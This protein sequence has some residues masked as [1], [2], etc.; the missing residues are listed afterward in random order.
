MSHNGNS[1]VFF[2]FF[3][4]PFLAPHLWHME[5][6]SPGVELELQLPSYTTAALNLSYI[7]D[8][9]H[10]F[11]QRWILNPLSKAR[12]WTLNLMGSSWILNPLSHNRIRLVFLK[13]ENNMW[14]K[15]HRGRPPCEAGGR[16]CSYATVR[17][18][19]LRTDG[20]IRSWEE[21]KSL[22][23]VSKGAWL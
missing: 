18:G 11:R 16:G 1:M 5:V 23:R 6:P 8:L 9:H 7:C 13:K 4:S 14:T 20:H 2:F 22:P 15:T 21:V 17:Q 12:G 3:F 19:T 10:S